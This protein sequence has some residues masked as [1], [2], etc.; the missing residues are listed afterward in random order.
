MDQDPPCVGFT[1]DKENC[2]C[3]LYVRVDEKVDAVGLYDSYVC[4]ENVTATGMCTVY[5]WY[6]L[7]II[8][9]DPRVLNTFQRIQGPVAFVAASN[10]QRHLSS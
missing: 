10:S 6:L 8:V 1:F 9:P 5:L 2:T 4:E 7:A 3:Q